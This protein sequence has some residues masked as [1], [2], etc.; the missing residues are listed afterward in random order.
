MKKIIFF[1]M[2]SLILL[3]YVG[4]TEKYPNK[5][6][7][8]DVPVLAQGS[9]VECHTDKELLKELATPIPPPSGDSGE[10]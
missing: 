9:C 6:E 2:S 5:I 1:I 8:G 4:C 3:L 7:G 10:G